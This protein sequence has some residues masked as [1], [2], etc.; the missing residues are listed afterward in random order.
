MELDKDYDYTKLYHPSKANA[1][2]D[3]LSRKSIGRLAY[4][5]LKRR[6]LVEEIHKLESKKVHFELKRL[7][8]LLAH[9]QT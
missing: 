3:V 2:V 4:I 6:P 8:P 1:V 7:G 5:T 9:V